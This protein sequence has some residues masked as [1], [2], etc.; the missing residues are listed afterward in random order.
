MHMLTKRK[1]I[2]QFFNS[3]PLLLI[4]TFIVAVLSGIATLLIPVFIGKYYQ[5]VLETDS[6]R[7][8]YFDKLF[9]TNDEIV[10]FFILFFSVIVLKSVF[11]FLQKYLTG[12][13]SE[14]F[15][16]KLREDLL[17][18]QMAFVMQVHERKPVG[19]YLLRYSGDLNA[20]QRY[21]SGGI[22][23][24]SAD[25]L[26]LL[27]T[28]TFAL[29]LQKELALILLLLA[30]P[31]FLIIN[32]VN[33]NLKVYTL[34]RRNI[35][36]ENLSFVASRLSALMT[37]KIFNRERIEQE[38]FADNSG[39]LFNYGVKYYR[40]FAFLNSLVPFL[41]YLIVMVLMVSVY[42]MKGVWNI[43]I[44]VSTLLIFLM[45][46]INLLP[47][48]K[49]VLRVNMIWQ[50]GDISFQKVLGIFNSP[51][52]T[53]ITNAL[54]MDEPG[55][56]EFNS[57]TFG[58]D[59]SNPVIKNLS[60]RINPN[61]VTL[62]KGNQGSGKSTLFKLLLGLYP[63]NSGIITVNETDISGISAFS[64]RKK[65]TLVSD[66]LPLLG[67]TIFESV[68]YSRKKEKRVLAENMLKK[69]NF[70]TQ[71]PE[72]LDID[73]K[74]DEQGRN[75]S[76]GQRKILLITRALLTRKKI[77]LLD[78]PFAGLDSSSRENFIMLLNNLKKK[79]TIIIADDHETPG[80]IYDQV[81]TL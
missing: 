14:L 16:K 54:I 3:Y 39:K 67:K 32:M 65:I 59:K 15:S 72:L 58:Y 69:F 52:E 24:F 50:A 20:I 38:K 41:I 7:G 80:I 34:K 37:V 35:R 71:A 76:R 60:F 26:F 64:L 78:E 22:I 44:P 68:S 36:S 31:A 43:H 75:L 29:F 5:I 46:V 27:M 21:I 19:K 28:I 12:Y 40:W 18:K 55:P 2:F 48:F 70:G 9:S 51:E 74:V 73:Y 1:L 13:G 25:I 4:S 49:R 47:V 57:V 63:C 79:R 77:L 33:K 53:R 45:L 30:P 42:Y 66:E 17:T 11:V 56:V 61:E 81:I 8:K 62:I 10:A 6:L 23:S